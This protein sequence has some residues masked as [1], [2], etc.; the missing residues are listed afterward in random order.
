MREAGLDM[1]GEFSTEN[2]VF[3]LL[4]N[5]NYIDNLKNSTRKVYDIQHTMKES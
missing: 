4:R 3:K 2:I 5:N 1:A